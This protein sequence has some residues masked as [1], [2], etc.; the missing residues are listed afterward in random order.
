MASPLLESGKNFSG[1]LQINFS[2]LSVHSQSITENFTSFEVE[3]SLL[4]AFKLGFLHYLMRT[5]LGGCI[6]STNCRQYFICTAFCSPEK[7]GSD[8]RIRIRF[9]LSIKR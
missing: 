4:Q 7:C 9:S 2:R 5:T 3:L 6:S 8:Q 1:E